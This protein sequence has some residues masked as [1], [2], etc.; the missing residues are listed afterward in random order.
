MRKQRDALFDGFH[1]DAVEE[2]RASS[3]PSAAAN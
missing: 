2:K 3:V 1:M